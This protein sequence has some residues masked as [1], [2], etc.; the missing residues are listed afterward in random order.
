MASP[1]PSSYSPCT[2]YQFWGQAAE[3]TGILLT[4]W[5]LAPSP[6]T[7]P[8]TTGAPPTMGVTKSLK[9]QTP[10]RLF[11]Q[12]KSPHPA[13]P[14]H[15]GRGPCGRLDAA[16]FPVLPAA[17][18]TGREK[19][20]SRLRSLQVRPASSDTRERSE[21][22]PKGP[23]A[24]RGGAPGSAGSTRVPA[25]ATGSSSPLEKLLTPGGRAARA[26]RTRRREACRGL[27]FWGPRDGAGR[28]AHT[29]LPA[30]RSS[31]PARQA[32]SGRVGWRRRG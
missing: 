10:C 30:L 19:T 3:C 12:G 1:G 18:L 24:G 28:R 5:L 11:C 32:G 21:P 14:G 17:F 2:S 4:L 26:A 15:L 23:S 31:W 8:I 20:H 29:Y 25:Q 9:G 22:P 6:L 7:L 27:W 16:L 13:P